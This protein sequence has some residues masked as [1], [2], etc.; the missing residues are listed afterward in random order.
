[1]PKLTHF[2][3]PVA[4]ATLLL[5]IAQADDKKPDTSKLPPAAVGKVDFDADIKPILAAHCVKCHGPTKQKGGLRLDTG[6]HAK[7][8]GNSGPVI[9]AGKSAESTLIHAVAGV[10]PASPM[11]PGEGKR[12]SDAEIGKLRAW[13]DQGARWGGA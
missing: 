11:P 5:A 4:V 1:M 2:I 6:T 10:E 9:V 12:L 7:E 8:G 13:I 3:P